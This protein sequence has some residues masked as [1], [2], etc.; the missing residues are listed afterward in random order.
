M[1]H[2]FEKCENLEYLDL[3]SFKINKI[4]DISNM[5]I[6]CLKLHKQFLKRVDFK[7]LQQ[8][9]LSQNEISDIDIL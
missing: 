2:M 5:F 8:L 4:T 7:Q 6:D 9:D 1:S 3:S